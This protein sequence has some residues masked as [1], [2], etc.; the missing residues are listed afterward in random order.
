[1]TAKALAAMN[2]VPPSLARSR[3]SELVEASNALSTNA[4]RRKLGE[5]GSGI[6][7][8]VVEGFTKGI[9]GS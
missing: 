4:R 3:G 9:I 5:L 7:S 6:V 8:A 2:A 1:L